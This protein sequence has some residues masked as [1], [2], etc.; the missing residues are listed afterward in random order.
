VTIVELRLRTLGDGAGAFAFDSIPA[1]TWR[2]EVRRIGYRTSVTTIVVR[3]GEVTSLV[4]RL[5]PLAVTLTGVTTF[6]RSPERERFE[7]EAQTSTRSLDVR[8]MAAVPA[9][10]ESDLLRTVQLLPGVVARNDFS[11]GLNVRGGDADQNLVRLGG[12]VLFNPFHLGGILSTFPERAI[13]SADF[14]AGGFPARYGGRLS[15]VLDVEERVGTSAGL[16]GSASVSLLAST[17]HFEG[18]LPAGA[19]SWLLA[20]RRTYADQLVAAFSSEEF[21]YHFQDLMG[22]V[23]LPSVQGGA[24]SLTGFASGDY[25]DFEITEA[26]SVQGAQRFGFDWGNALVGATWRRPIGERGLLTQRLGGSGFFADVEVGPGLF[27]FENRLRRLALEGDFEWRGDRHATSAGYVLERHDITYL[28]TS[29]E[30][31]VDVAEL[32]YRPTALEAYLDDQWQVT[33]WLLLRPGVRF[34]HV[35]GTGFARLAPRFASKLFLGANTALSA[36]GGRYYQH[37]HS[38]RNEEIPVTLFEFWVGTDSTLPVSSA[39][40][41]VLGLERWFGPGLSLSVEAFWKRMRNLVDGDPEED[42]AVRGDEFQTARGTAYGLDLYLHQ[43]TGPLTGWIAYTFGKVSRVTEDGER[44]APA[45]DRR[46]TL[47]V[48]GTFAG[49]LG[50]RWTVRLGYGSPLPYTEIAG[51]WIHRFYDPGRNIFIGAFTEP[52]RGPRNGARYPAYSRLDV[53]ARWHFSWL[54]ARWSPGVSVLNAY[55]RTNVFTYLYDY[56]ENPPVRRGFSQL[57]FLP[58]VGLEVEW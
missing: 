1:G 14:V 28:A 2:L 43:T 25:F 52:Y 20:A 33:P 48:V 16:H 35:R 38:L 15:S 19:G 29:S 36:S 51:Q 54:G 30:L 12:Q 53:S 23:V 39:D 24:V 31:G 10:A 58:T 22:R 57:P 5:T 18:P 55:A 37:I 45:Q 9:L 21:P 8:D 27:R 42:P 46:H 26:N 6:G 13:Q 47:N 34:T 56:T 32:E 49:P 40:H 4:V 7:R 3:A 50:A 41:A 44:F 11:V 17:A